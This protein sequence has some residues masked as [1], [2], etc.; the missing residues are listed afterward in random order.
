MQSH[1]NG[2]LSRNPP[3][4]ISLSL[5]SYL[6]LYLSRRVV[7]PMSKH[8]KHTKTVACDHCSPHPGFISDA[9]DVIL[10]SKHLKHTKNRLV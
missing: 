10:M 7:I 5:S 3:R 8:T 4:V 1:N 2:L 6:S 9:R